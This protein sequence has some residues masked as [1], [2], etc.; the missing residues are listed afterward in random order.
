MPQVRLIGEFEQLI[1]LTVL[2]C[3]DDAYGY[4]IQLELKKT[5]GRTASLGAIYTTLDRLEKKGY[6]SSCLASAGA[7]PRG[8]RPRRLYAVDG[9]G[10]RVINAAQRRTELLMEGLEG[11]LGIA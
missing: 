3:R 11:V 9:A 4:T 1:L 10:I 5:L 2:R 8:G 6:V 7:S